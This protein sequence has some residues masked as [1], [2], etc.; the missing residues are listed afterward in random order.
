MTLE[1]MPEDEAFVRE[2]L[3]GLAKGAAVV[4]GYFDLQGRFPSVRTI[5]V[6]DRSEFD[7]CVAEVLRI[8]IERPSNPVR[9][10]Q[11]QGTDLILVSPRAYVPGIN[12]YT[13]V[14]FERLIV[15]EVTHI[16]EEYLSPNIETL[17]RWWSEGLAML[18]S[19]QWKEDLAA[20][21]KGVVECRVPS[22]SELRDGH[23]TDASV[24]LCYV[25]GWTIVRYIETAHGQAGIRRVVEQC[26]DGDV[27]S[28]LG[29][30]I[31]TFERKW[32]D[33]LVD[34]CRDKE[35]NVQQRF[36]VDGRKPPAA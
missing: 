27:L 31:G 15:H 3:S 4:T 1:Y 25:W 30:D 35:D 14:G 32:K 12:R 21:L 8:Q 7:R 18:L 2:T 34:F 20:V 29:E 5:L 26:A 24:W 11:P 33:W 10:G 23:M 6:P 13:P 17:P 28:T 36:Q 16:A 19:E 22:L 9:V